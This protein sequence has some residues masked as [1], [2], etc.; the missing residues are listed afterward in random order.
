MINDV[1]N[2]GD[3]LKF[4]DYLTEN[5]L[6]FDIKQSRSDSL[7][8]TFTVILFR[9]EVDFFVDH[10]EYSYFIGDEWVKDDLRVLDHII[11]EDPSKLRELGILPQSIRLR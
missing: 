5:S 10:I 1:K 4:L 8:V 7:M 2:L 3:I 6:K 11:R 9:V